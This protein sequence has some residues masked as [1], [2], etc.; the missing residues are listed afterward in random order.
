MTILCHIVG[1][2]SKVKKEFIDYVTNLSPDIVVKDIDVLTN[3]IRLDKQM[4]QLS[5]RF[6]KTNDQSV[7]YH[8]SK[9]INC[10]WKK[11]LAD[12]IGN[13]VETYTSKRLILI[14][15]NTFYKNNRVRVNIETENKFF[16]NVNGT[17]NAMHIVEHNLDKYRQSMI[18]GTFPLKFLDHDFLIKQ[19]EQLYKIYANMGYN[20]MNM[21]EIR[22]WIRKQA[23]NSSD[24]ANYFYIGHKKDYNRVIGDVN[25]KNENSLSNLSAFLE[26]NNKKGMIGY[27]QKWLAL[28][29]SINSNN[30][31]FEK[32]YNKDKGVV[33]PYLKEASFNSFSKLLTS[34]YLYTIDVNYAD[35]Q[36][37]W[38]KYNY[39]LPINYQSKEFIENIYEALIKEGV[40][41]IEYQYH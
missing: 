41:L 19:R 4:S 7:K 28:V 29:S 2:N 5:Q 27:T 36:I 12:K 6:H 9:K 38:Y 40:E 30:V 22:E 18:D 23:N 33:T 14:G 25:I 1:I 3:D 8:L 11:L 17:I 20:E 16:L 37:A 39:T 32:G 34:C 35:K 31:Y 15:Q 24:N 26:F 13:I 10:L 21:N